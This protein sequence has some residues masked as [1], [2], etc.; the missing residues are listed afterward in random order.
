M[1]TREEIVNVGPVG[2]EE[3]IP[4]QVFLEPLRQVFVAGMHRH[5]IDRGGIDHHRQCTCE[6]SSL[7]GLEILLTQHLRRDIGRCTILTR[8][9]STIAEI[10]LGAGAYVEA[11]D[12][13][14]VVALIAL[15]LC[16]HHLTVDDGILAEALVDTRPTGIAAQ[17]H[18]GVIH[19]RTV[20]C[21]TFIGRNLSTPEGQV[22]IKRSTEVD[23]LREERASCCISHTMVMVETIDI[24]NAQILHRLLLNQTD[25]L[26]PLVD[27]GCAGTRSIQNRT[28]LPLGNQR[29]KHRLVKFPNAFG[30]ALVEIDGEI[31]EP[32]DNLLIRQLHHFVN[33]L[34]RTT[35]LLEHGAHLITIHFRIL[36]GGLAHHVEVQFKHLA[37]LLVKGH[38]G[39]CF[40]NL[41]L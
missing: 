13:V 18:N 23:G 14:V 19:P 38:L 28:H 37:D 35:I 40:L 29:V 9:R 8:P 26:L 36:N 31:A 11:V 41:C 30:I 22:C 25:P 2:D 6:R 34:G 5:T 39:E 3:S 32:V 21:A 33:F 7:E 4:L 16:C 27:T 10:V 1:L 17:V 15:D 12:M 20:G 24:G